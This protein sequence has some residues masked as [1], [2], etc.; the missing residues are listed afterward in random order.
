LKD[1]EWR[2]GMLG[3]QRAEG[4]NGDVELVLSVH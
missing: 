4:R 2:S 3:K 1:K